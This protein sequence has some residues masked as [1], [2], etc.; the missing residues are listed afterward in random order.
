MINA[1]DL[2]GNAAPPQSAP[3]VWSPPFVPGFRQLVFNE[4]MVDP[5]PPVALPAREY[6]EL[7]NAAGRAV[8]LGGVRLQDELGEIT[9]PDY[10]LDSG[11]YVTLCATAAVAELQTFGPVLGVSLPN[12]RNGG[13]ALTLIGT[14]STVL[15]RVSYTDDWYD[16]EAKDGGGW[17]LEQINPSAT[18][19]GAANWRAATHPDGGTPGQL[20]SVF[21]DT[22]DR[23]PPTL[24]RAELIGSD[25]L[26]LHF[27]EGMDSLSLVRGTYTFDPPLTVAGVLPHPGF[28][29]VDLVVPDVR[30]GV[31]YTVRTG[32]VTDCPGNP[33]DDGAVQFG[34]GRVPE[35]AELLIN[36]IMADPEPAVGLPEEEYLELYNAGG[37]LLELG[38]LVLADGNG[39]I[40]LPPYQLAAG[41]HLILCGTGSVEDF[42][43]FGTTLG[44]SGFPSLRN[45]GETL[46]LRTAGGTVLDRVDYSDDWYDD[47]AKADGGWA[48]ERVNPFEPCRGG[49]NWRASTDER[50][51]TPG[52][53]NATFD[54]TPDQT[55][56]A[57]LD[58]ALVGGDTLRLRFSEV[59]S[60]TTLLSGRYE[61][62]PAGQVRRVVPG[63]G[64]RTV[65]LLLA[66]SLPAGR[67]YTVTVGD[68]SDCSGNVLPDTSATFG[69]GRPPGRFEVLINEIMADP[70]P[71]VG[72]PEAEYLELYNATGDLLELG[73][74]LLA[75]GGTTTTLPPYPLLPDAYVI[76][77]GT[78]SVGSFSAFGPTLG[79]SSFP[80]LR[81]DGEAL[82]LRNEAGTLIHRVEYSD[83]W[84][85]DAL[86]AEGGWSL[87][88]VDA[89]R[90]C[91]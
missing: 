81:N 20:N 40:T 89:S 18:C 12:L 41:Q 5:T 59:L 77:C 43:A 7:F 16:D 64:L 70:E 67:L 73:G 84:Y 11:A 65:Q 63:A 71:A 10:R 19:G 15:D 34:L 62:L 75:D 42:A 8:E 50:G 30:A 36:E 26:R 29:A 46:E 52:Q 85:D 54:D 57:L 24:L 32:G 72:L 55:P 25:T 68:V 61:L 76:L 51:G 87:E 56:P 53:Q 38:G 28:S 3:F 33:I 17:S 14:D 9:L 39:E 47:E 91:G 82:Q 45:D 49:D 60:E 27:S 66:E 78:G 86:K 35:G 88:Q 58:A 13:E 22:P 79:V 80:S 48:L 1:T 37:D 74:V 44:V 90:P 31:L 69:S 21:D 83:A 23:T 6:V 2:A 4:L